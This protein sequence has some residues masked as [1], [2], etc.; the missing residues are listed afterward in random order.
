MTLKNF[1]KQL[2]EKNTLIRLWY[3]TDKGHET[4]DSH[5]LMMEWEWILSPYQDY[6]VIGVTDILTEEYK[7]AVNIVVQRN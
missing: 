5:P 4:V 7:E 2:V 1:I 6:K 3:K